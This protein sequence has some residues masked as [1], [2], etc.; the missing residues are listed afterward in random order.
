MLQLTPYHLKTDEL[1]KYDY[2]A[3]FLD[4]SLIPQDHRALMFLS[5]TYVFQIRNMVRKAASMNQMF[6]SGM[7]DGDD[8]TKEVRRHGQKV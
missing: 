7:F 6:R 2:V 4:A 1:E 8:A 5:K 3:L